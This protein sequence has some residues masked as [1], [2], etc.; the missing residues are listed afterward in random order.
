MTASS[1][2]T[3]IAGM[4][5]TGLRFFSVS[6]MPQEIAPSQCPAMFPAP[7]G[8]LGEQDTT[9]GVFDNIVSVLKQHNYTLTYRLAYAPAGSGRGLADH[10]S[11]IADM[12]QA[13]QKALF[14]I[15]QTMT[16]IERVTVSQ[17]GTIKDPADNSFYGCTVTVSARE[18]M[19]KE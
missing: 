6:L 10:Y 11:G 14:Q 1:L 9:P 16:T 4:T 2:D 13:I 3:A 15:D 19:T 18:Y 17:F 8:W 5:V 7:D 12:T